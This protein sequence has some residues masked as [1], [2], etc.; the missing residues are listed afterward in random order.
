MLR[1]RKQSVCKIKIMKQFMVAIE[2]CIC[3][4]KSRHFINP[5]LEKIDQ[6]ITYCFYRR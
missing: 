5:V 1:L 4:Q 3:W 2:I 6:H